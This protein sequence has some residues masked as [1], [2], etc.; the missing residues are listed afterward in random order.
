MDSGDDKSFLHEHREAVFR[1]VKCGA[2]QAVC[3]TYQATGDEAQVA[4]GR[5]SLLEAV[6]DGR[7]GITRGLDERISKCL[8][9]MACERICP[10]GLQ[11]HDIFLAA[12]SGMTAARDSH[13]LTRQAVRSAARGSASPSSVIR[14]AGIVGEAVY[15]ILPGSRL[16]PWWRD[17]RK[18]SLPPLGRKTFTDIAGDETSL[19]GARRRVALF[20][21]CAT[22]LVYPG[23]GLAAVKLLAE[24]GIEVA[25]PRTL[26]CCGL[27]FLSLGDRESARAA[28]EENLSLLTGLGA[29]TIVTVCSSC[30]LMLKALLPRLLGEEREDAAALAASVRDIH[31]LLA[32]GELGAAGPQPAARVTWHDPCHMRHGLGMS[33][34]PRD[35]LAGLGGIEYI[36]TGAGCCGGAGAFSFLH[37]DLALKI[38]RPRAEEIAA[39]G[40]DFVATGCPGCRTH[41]TDVLRRAGSDARVVHTAE[42]VAGLVEP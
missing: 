37:Y 38:G 41:L 9:C 29:D 6:L 28:A 34:A 26:Q 13:R 23:T 27:P 42:L 1:C 40:V 30:A 32:G 21:G 11:I 12:R 7:L 31:E 33:A 18:R 16:A 25:H 17:G 15:N 20:P 35:I 10:S 24:A 2:C 39:A 8:G 5:L 14:T 22:N 36:E 19:S 4:R 3:P